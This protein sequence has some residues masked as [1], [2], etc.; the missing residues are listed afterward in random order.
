MNWGY[1]AGGLTQNMRNALG[2]V[3]ENASPR[4]RPSNGSWIL[5]LGG[6]ALGLER[7]SIRSS[8]KDRFSHAGAA[9]ML[10]KNSGE[11]GLIVVVKYA[12]AG[13]SFA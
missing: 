3:T 8:S 4:G 6:C 7:Y 1:T 2:C 13:E 11:P 9:V 12:V 5:V 10:M